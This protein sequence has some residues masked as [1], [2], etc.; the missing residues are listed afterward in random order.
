MERPMSGW[1]AVVVTILAT[2]VPVASAHEMTH[3]G[4]VQAVESGR[5]QVQTLD[6][7]G[8]MAELTW[9]TVGDETEVRRG[10]TVVAYE[11]AAIEIGERIVVIVDHDVDEAMALEVRLA[12]RGPDR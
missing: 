10:D 7:A 12:A 4:T 2:F 6:D 8:A 1:A 5:V 9:F 3:R 11:A